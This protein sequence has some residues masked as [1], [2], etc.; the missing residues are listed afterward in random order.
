MK[1]WIIITASLISLRYKE[2]RNEYI[3]GIRSILS[4]FSDR[5]KYRIVIVENTSKLTNE[6]AFFNATFLNK[7]GVPVLYTKNNRL[8]TRTANYGIIEMIDIN[9]CIDHF[10]IQDEDFIVKITGRYVVDTNSEFFDVVDKLD[11][12]PYSA[13]LRFSQFDEPISLVKTTNCTT[14]MIGLKCKYVKKI[15]IPNLEDTKT[16]IE[17]KWAKVISELDDSEICIMTKLGLYIRPSNMDKYCTDYFL[18]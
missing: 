1:I 13:I 18:L 2:R 8:I 3:A 11:K 16:A 4:K 5:N 10:K 9:A 12:K 17:M 7:F 15:E 6:S 14:G